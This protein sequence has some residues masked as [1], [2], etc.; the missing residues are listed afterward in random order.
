M[1]GTIVDIVEPID[2]EEKEEEKEPIEVEV[3]NNID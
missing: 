2:V 3:N 1:E